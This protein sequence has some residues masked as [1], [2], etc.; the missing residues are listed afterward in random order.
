MSVHGVSVHGVS[1]LV[2]A[3]D[4]SRLVKAGTCFSSHWKLPEP[5][6][7]QEDA[8]FQDCRGLSGFVLVLFLIL[9]SPKCGVTVWEL[10]WGVTAQLKKCFPYKNEGLNLILSHD[11]NE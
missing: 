9:L 3:D 1:T 8:R 5:F 11:G 6:F 10:G 2:K 7:V 4:R